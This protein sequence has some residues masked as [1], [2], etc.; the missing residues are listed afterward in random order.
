MIA[1]KYRTGDSFPV[2]SPLIAALSGDSEPCEETICLLKNQ[3]REGRCKEDAA[4]KRGRYRREMILTHRSRNEW[5]ERQ[6]EKKMQISPKDATGHP[7][8]GV[9]HMG[10]DCSSRCRLIQKLCTQLMITEGGAP[11]F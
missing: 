8:A 6:P 9:Q 11:A 7:S 5:K 1:H 2:Q 3:I 4:I 10:D